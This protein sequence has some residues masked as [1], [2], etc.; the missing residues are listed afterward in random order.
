M[1]VKMDLT[2]MWVELNNYINIKKYAMFVILLSLV[3]AVVIA[4][5]T[6]VVLFFVTRHALFD[7]FVLGSDEYNIGGAIGGISTFVVGIG[8]V[9]AATV[10]AIMLFLTFKNQ[11]I[12]NKQ[13]QQELIEQRTWYNNL[14]D[15][16]KKTEEEKQFLELRNQFENIKQFWFSIELI[17]NKKKY[18]GAD[19]IDNYV[20]LRKVPRP[21]ET[22][23]NEKNFYAKFFYCYQKLNLYL[24]AIPNEIQEK[25]KQQL[26]PDIKSFYNENMYLAYRDIIEKT[27]QCSENIEKWKDINEAI[28]SYF[29]K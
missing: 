14:N 29:K 22:I 17:T 4:V 21:K 25:H 18:S 20:S 24:C 1:V 11:S 7:S 27:G 15:K 28:E 3:I 12:V 16:I 13:Q 5:V 19:A 23:E 26:L 6:L 10:N 9:I 2:K 8:S